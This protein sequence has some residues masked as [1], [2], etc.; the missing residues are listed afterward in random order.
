MSYLLDT[1]VLSEVW[2]VK[3]NQGVID[4]LGSSNEDELHLSVLSLG[5]LKKGIDSLAD[6][7]KRARLL[8]DYTSIRSRFGTRIVGVNDAIAERWGEALREGASRRPPFARR[9]RPFGCDRARARSHRGHA[10]R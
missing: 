3:A 8:R 10:K 4:W 9:G 6:G 2:R 7:K 5:E 1:C